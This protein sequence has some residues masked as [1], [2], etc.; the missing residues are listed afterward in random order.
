LAGNTW[1]GIADVNSGWSLIGSYRAENGGYYAINADGI[2]SGY[3]LVDK[4]NDILDTDYADGSST[5]AFKLKGL[6]GKTTSTPSPKP[7]Q[8]VP[9]PAA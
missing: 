7:P 2:S 4:F 5:D 1:A 9:E 6:K 3:W 8:E